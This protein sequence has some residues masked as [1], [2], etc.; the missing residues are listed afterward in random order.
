[1]AKQGYTVDLSKPLVFQVGHL[2]D[3]YD[4]WVHQPIVGKE[5]PRFFENDLLE[6]LTRTPWWAIPTIWLPVVWWLAST[7]VNRG[8]SAPQLVATLLVGLAVWTLLEYS[9]HRFLFHKKPRG[10]WGNTLHYLFHGCH[11]KHPMDRMRLVFP[12]AAAVFIVVLVGNVIKLLTPLVY[13]PAIHGGVLLGYVIYDC[14]HYYLHHGKPLTGVSH[15]LK[16]YHMDHH[17]KAQNKGYGITSA[18]WDIVFGTFPP[19][20]TKKSR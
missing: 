1:M 13:A 2:G 14:T 7:S 20:P 19:E 11:H 8:L 18:F 12:P 3:A 9:L 17:F 15:S 4:E 10:Y 6:L 5:G 16:R